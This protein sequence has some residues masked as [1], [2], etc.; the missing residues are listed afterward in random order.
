VARVSIED[1]EVAKELLAINE[2]DAGEQEACH[3]VADWIAAEIKDR[4][5]TS[6]VRSVT[7][8]TNLSRTKV[9]KFLRERET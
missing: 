3:R 6:T 2:G 8:G 7:K 1:L 5:L 9:R 4:E